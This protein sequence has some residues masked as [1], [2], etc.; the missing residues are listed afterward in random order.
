VVTAA[1]G[2]E[3]IQRLSVCDRVPDAIVCDHR[4]RGTE[5]GIDVIAAIRIEFNNDIPAVL[6][7]GDT[8]PQRIQSMATTGIPVLNKPLQDHVLM[9]ALLRLLN[10]LPMA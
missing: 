1:S 4:L 5:T 6:V 8:S 9:D 10:R 3:A 2:D 7:T